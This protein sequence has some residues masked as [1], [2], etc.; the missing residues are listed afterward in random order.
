MGIERFENRVTNFRKLVVDFVPNTCRNKGKCL[1]QPFDV[2]IFNAI[3]SNP[4][5]SGYFRI[6]LRELAAPRPLR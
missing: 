3:G 1:N 5:S 2:R 4:E 6:S